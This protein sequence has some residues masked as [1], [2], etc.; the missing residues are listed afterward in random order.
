MIR[1][2]A[3]GA[4][5]W[6]E[7]KDDAVRLGVAGQVVAARQLNHIRQTCGDRGRARRTAHYG[8]A[9]IEAAAG[10]DAIER[11]G[12]AHKAGGLT[13]GGRKKRCG[14]DQGDAKRRKQRVWRGENSFGFGCADL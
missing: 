4:A 8:G 1:N 13:R 12:V 2:R 5:V 7:D 10:D 6:A 14:T 3:A 9:I 11:Y